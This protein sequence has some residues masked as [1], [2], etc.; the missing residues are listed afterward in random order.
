MCNIQEN[1]ECVAVTNNPNL[2]A[3]ENKNGLKEAEHWKDR[4]LLLGG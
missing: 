3:D 1:L 4:K 2:T